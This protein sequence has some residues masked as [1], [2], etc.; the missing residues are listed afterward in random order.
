[1]SPFPSPEPRSE[2]TL[3]LL[4]RAAP[5][6]VPRGHRAGGGEGVGASI[7]S[8]IESMFRYESDDAS[9]PGDAAGEEVDALNHSELE[10]IHVRHPFP[11][12][13]PT[14]AYVALRAEC[15]TPC[16]PPPPARTCSTHLLLVLP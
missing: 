9:G 8:S 1:M 5:L 13:S 12:R 15:H 7:W 3:L 10:T 6:S 4:A 11:K 2:R 14:P 16:S